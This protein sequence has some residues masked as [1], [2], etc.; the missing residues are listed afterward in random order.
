MGNTKNIRS[1]GFLLLLLC[2]SMAA[3]LFLYPRVHPFAGM[4]LAI[5]MDSIAQRAGH[6]IR[7]QGFTVSAKPLIMLERDNDRLR[8]LQTANGVEAANRIMRADGQVYYWQ[9][10]WSRAAVLMSTQNTSRSAPARRRSSDTLDSL[11]TEQNRVAD[12]RTS[13]DQFGMLRSFSTSRRD[14]AAMRVSRS[15]ARAIAETFIRSHNPALFDRLVPMREDLALDSLDLQSASTDTTM[16]HLF[17]WSTALS[18]SKDTLQISASVYG[19]MLVGMWNEIKGSVKDEDPIGWTIAKSTM[20]LLLIILV[21]IRGFIRFRSYELGPATGMAA[22]IIMFIGSSF[23]AI[24]YNL[25][26]SPV[27]MLM[28]GLIGPVFIGLF[29]WFMWNISEVTARE[30]G[31]DRFVE[32]DLLWKGRIFDARLGMGLLRAMAFGSALCVAILV[33]IAALRSVLPG[34]SYIL[35]GNNNHPWSLLA[36]VPVGLVNESVRGM[37]SS[38]APLLLLVFSMVQLWTSRSWLAVLF[39]AI[40]FATVAANSIQMDPFVAGLAVDFCI[41]FSIIVLFARYGLVT[42]MGAFLTYA[43]FMDGGVLFLTGAPTHAAA[44]TALALVFGVSAIGSALVAL[45]GD[46]SIDAQALQPVYAQRISERQRLQKELEV[47]RM[48][49]MSFLPKASPSVQGLDIASRCSPAYEVGGDYYDFIP[50]GPRRLA[51]AIGD[52]SGKGTHAAFYMTLTKGFLH[53]IARQHHAP[54]AVLSE[55][56]RLFYHNVA[57]GNFISMIYAVFDL[58]TRM[59]CIARAG[60]NPAF[61]FTPDGRATAIHSKGLALGFERGD[62][63]SATIEERCVPLQPGDFFLFYTDGFPEAMSRTREEFGEQRMLD[64][65]RN[66]DGAD[67]RACLDMLFAETGRFTG[68]ARQHDDMTAVVVKVT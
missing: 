11:L 1:V 32:R 48:V 12:V 62:L 27:D 37:L 33:L 66:L 40:V 55:L 63:F 51:V 4:N 16:E 49:Q 54:A 20:Y 28:A 7:A 6:L 2:I 47:A 3:I 8:A 59:I 22:G 31:T 64:A 13:Y 9:V 30:A 36:F 45:F 56:N 57:R 43:M 39:A 24:V 52:V 18:G 50:L 53:A 34:S 10:R 65:L 17:K 44:G 67:A 68:K 42:S 38:F 29:L 26:G 19:N 46:A 35:D 15:Q 58:D 61:H 60:H 23:S 21:V 14:S 5:P 25:D 41:G